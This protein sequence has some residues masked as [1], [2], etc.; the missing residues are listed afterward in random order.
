MAN[1]S[2]TPSS[3]PSWMERFDIKS[4]PDPSAKPFPYLVT[5]FLLIVIVYSLQGPRYP[6]N[7]KHLNPRAPLEFSDT[8]PKKEFVANSREMIAN[9]FKTN[10]DKP[11]RVISDFG[12]ITV[13]PP[14]FANEIKSDDRLSFSKWTYKVCYPWCVVGRKR[15]K[16]GAN[17]TNY[18]RPSMRTSP[19]SKGSV[20]VAVIRRLFRRLS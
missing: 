3:I 14:R 5:A 4:F 18:S 11:C 1:P 19:V 9:W 12:E 2:A 13:L 8:R 20:R 6:K 17:K 10:P 15:V 7:I 16:V